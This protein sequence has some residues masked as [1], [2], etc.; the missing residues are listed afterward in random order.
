MMERLV[1]GTGDDTYTFDVRCRVNTW[2]F[3]V[4]TCPRIPRE[5]YYRFEA[6]C[7]RIEGEKEWGSTQAMLTHFPLNSTP[8][9]CPHFLGV[10]W[11]RVVIGVTDTHRTVFGAEALEIETGDR[12]RVTDATARKFNNEG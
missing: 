4:P 11:N 7:I 3:P 2:D 8:I 6:A 9:A 12:H 5:I 1:F 10:E